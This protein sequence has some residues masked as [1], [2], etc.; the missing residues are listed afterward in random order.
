MSISTTQSFEFVRSQPRRNLAQ[1]MAQV[2]IFGLLCLSITA[3]AITITESLPWIKAEQ[4]LLPLVVLLYGWMLLSGS[5]RLIRVNGMFAIGALYC[6]SILLSIWYGAAILHH[7][8]LFR[9]YY[10]LPKVWLPVIFFTIAYESNLS[11]SS[12]RRLF[13]YFAP[14]VLVICFYAWAQFARLNF[15]YKLN[16]FYSGGAHIDEGLLNH[17]RV[18]ST[19]G[20]ANVLGQLMTWSIIVFIMA[21]LFGVGSR[22]RNIAVTFACLVALAMT[23]S[24]YG[25][26]TTAIG[27]ALIFVL[28]SS[29]G[30]RRFAQ[31]ALLTV[32]VPALV[33]AFEAT[34]KTNQGNVQRI[35][36]LRHPLEVDSLRARLDDLWRDAADDF[37]RSPVLGY[38]PAKIFYTGVFTDSEYLDVLKEFGIIGFLPYLAYYFFPM[39]LLWR[40]LRASQRAG[41][42]WEEGFPATFLTLRFAFILAVTALVMNIG[43]STFYNQLL[44]AFLWLWLGL[45]ASCAHKIAAASTAFRVSDGSREWNLQRIPREVA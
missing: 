42:A 40:G 37:L 8:I 15:T 7:E 34:V 44:Q 45:G 12:L 24:R 36:S 28:P 30:R 18:Y 13:N 11:E 17:G 21:F 9:D 38:G 41:P 33:W 5:A 10:E 31:L 25:L 6:F 1:V 29:F 35:E 2:A 26:L 43:E 4:L 20:N 19:M 23:G 14:T 22:V 27:L 3:P 16:T 32:L 39:L